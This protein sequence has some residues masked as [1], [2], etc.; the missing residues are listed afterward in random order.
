VSA[1][2]LIF[3]VVTSFEKRENGNTKM[4]TNFCARLAE[5]SLRLRQNGSITRCKLISGCATEMLL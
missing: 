1:A 5:F 4:N 3:L 2:R